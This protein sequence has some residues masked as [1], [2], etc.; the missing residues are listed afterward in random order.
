MIL[1]FLKL[2]GQFEGQK[3]F[4]LPLIHHRNCPQNSAFAFVL[5]CLAG[6]RGEHVHVH[7]HTNTNSGLDFRKQEMRLHFRKSLIRP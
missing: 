4:D 2:I 1:A 5:L 3:A 6:L 7:V